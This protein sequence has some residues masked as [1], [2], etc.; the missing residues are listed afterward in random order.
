MSFLVT[1]PG[2]EPIIVEGWFNAPPARVFQAW[3]E[4][5]EIKKWFGQQPYALASAEIDLRL[6]GA[7]RFTFPPMNATT[8]GF[9]GA[10]EEIAPERKLAFT[11]RR[12]DDRDD[13]RETGPVSR[14]DVAFSPKGA[15]T[16]VRLVH[17]ALAT[18]DARR[19]VAGGWGGA[20][21]HLE[22]VF[23]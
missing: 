1:E 12:F 20:F 5:E 19:S 8:F 16:Q 10:Y 14:V 23:A 3:T 15:G 6:G 18:D 21:T 9:E 7:W 4:P 13:G 17:A 11:W 2:A 22:A